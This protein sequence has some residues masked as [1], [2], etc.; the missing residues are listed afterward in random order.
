[1]VSREELDKIIQEEL[2]FLQKNDEKVK[3]IIQRKEEVEA[4]ARERRRQIVIS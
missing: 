3:L 4:Q 2:E 1:M